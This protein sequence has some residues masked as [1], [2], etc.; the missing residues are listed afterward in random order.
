MIFV[1]VFDEILPSGDKIGSKNVGDILVT[2]LNYYV[3]SISER[4]NML[5][6]MLINKGLAVG[7]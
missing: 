4:R 1:L 3:L 6:F 7:V 5:Q 2:Y